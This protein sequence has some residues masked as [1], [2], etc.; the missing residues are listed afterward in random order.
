MTKKNYNNFNSQAALP[1][2]PGQESV[3]QQ[4]QRINACELNAGNISSGGAVDNGNGNVC[5]AAAHTCSHNENGNSGS[6]QAPWGAADAAKVEVAVEV[7]VRHVNGARDQEKKNNRL[8]ISS[9]GQ[10]ESGAVKAAAR[11]RRGR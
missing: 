3:E 6:G 11:G 4:S 1:F 9:V 7:E 10:S 5:V 8:K 2:F